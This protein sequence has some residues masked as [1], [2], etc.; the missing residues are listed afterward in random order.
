VAIPDQTQ[1]AVPPAFEGLFRGDALGF[2][3]TLR[4]DGTPQLTP[5]WVDLEEGL[6]LVN[7]RADRLKARNL[8]RNGEAAVCVADPANPFRYISVTGTVESVEE[9]GALPHMDSLARRYLRVRKY[10]WAS[11]GERRLLFRIRPT[12]VLVDSGEVEVPEPEL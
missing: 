3:A 7:V 1:A 10:P 12:R 8:Q 5:V 4:A 9:E 6:I 2:L 11:P